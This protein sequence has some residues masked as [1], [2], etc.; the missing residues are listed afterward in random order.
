MRIPIKSNAERA[1]SV[2]YLLL[3]HFNMMP[4]ILGL[5]LLHEKKRVVLQS[6]Q[7]KTAFK[8]A[9]KLRS[10]NFNR[11]P[12]EVAQQPVYPATAKLDPLVKFRLLTN[13]LLRISKEEEGETNICLVKIGTW[14]YKQATHGRGVSGGRWKDNFGSDSSGLNKLW[15]EQKEKHP[16]HFNVDKS[17]LRQKLIAHVLS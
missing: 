16:R 12:Y 8:K 6:A 7:T 3:G 5:V 17:M 11:L 13:H 14:I 9:N 15:V 1:V 2:T 10:N 4:V